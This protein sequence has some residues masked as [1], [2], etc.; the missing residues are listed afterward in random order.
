[1]LNVLDM[2][3]GSWVR[4][5]PASGEA[6]WSAQHCMAAMPREPELAL[7]LL[8]VAEAEEQRAANRQPRPRPW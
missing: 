5:C 1:M 2:S 8:T 3:A 4:E 7:R 6:E